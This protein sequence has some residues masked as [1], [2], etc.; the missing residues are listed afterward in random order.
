VASGTTVTKYNTSGVSQGSFSLTG[1]IRTRGLWADA[2][3]IYA[4]TTNGIEIYNSSGVLQS[5]VTALTSPGGSAIPLSWNSLGKVVRTS[6]GEF[7]FI[8]GESIVRASSSWEW[9]ATTYFSSPVDMAIDS[10]D[11]VYVANSAGVTR[12]TLAP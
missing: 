5:T 6:G 4:A 9:L 8:W 1:S 10:S 12:Y 2:S 7:L 11:R 3:S